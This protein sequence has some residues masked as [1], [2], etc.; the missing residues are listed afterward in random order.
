MPFENI[1]GG[2]WKQGWPIV[3]E[4]RDWLSDSLKPKL[5]VHVVPHSHNDP[6][7]L[8]TFDDYFLS[9]TNGILSSV[10]AALRENERRHFIW[11][12][13]SFFDKWW[14]ANPDKHEQFREILKTGRFEFVTGGW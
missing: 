4:Q 14:S 1:D 3:L 11:A 9:Q 7:W 5:Q 8:K 10:L 12:E 2:A 13:I 6:G